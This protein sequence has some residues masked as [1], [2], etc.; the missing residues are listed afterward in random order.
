MEVWRAITNTLRCLWCVS[1]PELPLDHTSPAVSLP[2]AKVDTSTIASPAQEATSL[3]AAPSDFSP[4][5]PS[6]AATPLPPSPSPP[7][8]Q[9]TTTQ[10]DAAATQAPSVPP[11]AQPP[12]D[13]S[14]Q[15]RSSPAVTG[16]ENEQQTKTTGTSPSIANADTEAS[17]DQSPQPPEASSTSSE[18]EKPALGASVVE[19]P[20]PV[21]EGHH[22]TTTTP[23]G[24]AD[25]KKTAKGALLSILKIA[26]EASAPLPPL[27]AVLGGVVAS[28]EIYDVSTRRTINKIC[29]LT[30][31]YDRNIVQIK[32]Q[33]AGSKVVFAP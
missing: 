2:Q 26:K 1:N 20:N 29:T 15:T 16:R 23:R 9:D 17:L 18:P 30:T 5:H 24:W 14:L 28:V 10:S 6:Q 27:Q 25:F 7:P 11:I 32:I 31:V 12:N 8:V 33:F 13:T 3:A 19:S 22:S 21:G 4:D